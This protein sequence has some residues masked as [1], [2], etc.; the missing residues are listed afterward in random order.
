MGEMATPDQVKDAHDFV[1]RIQRINQEH[2][3]GGNLPPDLHE[4]AVREALGAFE[5]LRSSRSKR[6]PAS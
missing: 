2:G 5:G 6:P 3:M 4:R 1:E